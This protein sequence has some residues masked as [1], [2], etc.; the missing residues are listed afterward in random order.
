[1]PFGPPLI[2]PATLR[3]DFSTTADLAAV[4]RDT[5]RHAFAH[6]SRCTSTGT[7]GSD[8][9][10][11]IGFD[12][13]EAEL[14]WLPPGPARWFHRYGLRLADAPRLGHTARPPSDLARPL[15]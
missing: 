8:S 2:S 5:Q 12:L 15:G 3:L 4:A 6:V 7:S 14:R 9:L 10:T 13:R 1:M 11:G